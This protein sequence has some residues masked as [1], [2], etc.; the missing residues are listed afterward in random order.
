MRM[1]RIGGETPRRFLGAPFAWDTS[2]D[3]AGA[4]RSRPMDLRRSLQRDAV[5]VVK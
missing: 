3:A 5:G 1:G 2:H 4:R